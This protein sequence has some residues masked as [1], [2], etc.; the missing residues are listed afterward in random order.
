MPKPHPVFIV[1]TIDSDGDTW[2]VHVC[3]T[4]DTAQHARLRY[5]AHL[6]NEGIFPTVDE[7]ID[8]RHMR[9]AYHTVETR[10]DV[11]SQYLTE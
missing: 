10:E 3:D 11:D 6:V 1:T 8:S 2:I 9:I 4:L 5:A 7:A